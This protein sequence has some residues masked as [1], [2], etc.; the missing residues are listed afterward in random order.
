MIASW[1]FWETLLSENLNELVNRFYSFIEINHLNNFVKLL[2]LQCCLKEEVLLFY[3][4][5]SLGCQAE[6]YAATFLITAKAV[7]FRKQLKYCHRCSD[8][9]SIAALN[10]LLPNISQ[11]KCNFNLVTGQSCVYKCVE[12]VLY[13]LEKNRRLCLKINK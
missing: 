13:V 12:S 3:H 1:D 5:N 10:Q 11:D 4:L 2:G 6:L 8:V 7:I 9:N